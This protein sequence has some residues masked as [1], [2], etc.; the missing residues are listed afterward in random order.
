MSR[1][2]RFRKTALGLFKKRT[3]TAA[4][5]RREG[6]SCCVM[7]LLW[8]HVTRMWLGENAIFESFLNDFQSFLQ[9][10]E[11]CFGHEKYSPR[12]PNRM[13]KKKQENSK[14]SSLFLSSSPDAPFGVLSS[15][16]R[17]RI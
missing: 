6:V 16:I 11:A 12:G 8:S 7:T 10:F 3:T 1:E 4:Q 5:R 17:H 14:F 15:P 9:T 2:K 13:N